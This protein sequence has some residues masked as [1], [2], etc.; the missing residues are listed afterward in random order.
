MNEKSYFREQKDQ[1]YTK[2]QITYI[3][4]G[5]KRAKTILIGYV[6]LPE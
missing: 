3:L 5:L 2:E 1:Q 4:I 6:M